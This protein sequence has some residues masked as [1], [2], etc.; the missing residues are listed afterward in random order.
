MISGNPILYKNGI[1][2]LKTRPVQLQ[3]KR[4]KIIV[5]F[6]VLFLGKDEAVLEI[7]FLQKFN[8]KIDW[9]T[10]NMEIKDIKSCKQW[11]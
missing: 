6:N 5:L 7:P 1:I 11:Q 3:V 4:Q 2:Y 9:I 10:R 8:L